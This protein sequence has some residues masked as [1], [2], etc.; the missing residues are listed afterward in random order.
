MNMYVSNLSFQVQEE[1]L[2][3]LFES[4]GEVSSAKIIT[5]RETG[6]SRGFGFVEMSSSEQ[7]N[8]AMSSLNNKEIEGRTISITVARE[9]EPRNQQRNW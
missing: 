3:Q 6:R 7:A 1:D 2:R 8:K 4:F 9:K 5:D